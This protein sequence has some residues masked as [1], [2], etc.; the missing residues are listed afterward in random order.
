VGKTWAVQYVAQQEPEPED[1]ISSP[2]LYTTVDVKNTPGSL[3]ANLLN[4][5]GP[6]YRAPVPEMINLT[7]CWTHRRMVNLIILDEA[8]RLDKT[9]REVIRDIPDRTRCAFLLVGQPDLPA[10][11]R[12][13]E[14]FLNRVSLTVEMVPLNFDGLVEFLLNWQERR[15]KQD[16]RE[17][18]EASFYII[19]NQDP[20][21]LHIIKEI[22]RVTLGN[23]R[24]VEQFIQ[25]AEYIA[26]VNGHAFVGLPVAEA[27]AIMLADKRKR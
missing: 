27:V 3:L 16:S 25:E 15:P 9:S 6:D 5:L 13:D 23:L 20:E 22:Y 10:K 18:R 11:L 26:G 7:C 21:E 17:S 19:P 12:R 4:C 24:R 1:F 8:D 14:P 2:V